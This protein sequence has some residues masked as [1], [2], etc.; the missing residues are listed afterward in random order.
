M[1]P[2]EAIEPGA[3]TLITSDGV[4]RTYSWQHQVPPKYPKEPVGANSHIINT[5]SKYKPFAIARPQ[6]NPVF[7]IYAGEIRREVSIFP[8]WNHWPSAFEPS[9][10]RYALAADR[11]SHSS[12]THMRWDEYEKGPNLLKKFM[13]EG[14]TDGTAADVA[15][16]S[17]SW[18]NAPRVS[19]GGVYDPKQRAYVFE[20]PPGSGRTGLAFR[21]EATEDSPV[22]NLALVVKNWG[23]QGAALA[24]NGKPVPQGPA[25]RL[26]RRA[27]VEEA[28]LVVWIKLDSE[29]PVDVSLQ[30]K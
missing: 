11:A 1:S 16:L 28:D 23:G 20:R 5:R 24:L 7:D 14:L 18:S 10:G 12:L 9:N 29:R 26:G 3:V 13:L 27:M 21:V 25:F 4:A 2:A 15:A 30:P 19:S 22:R 17:R 6:D 8:W